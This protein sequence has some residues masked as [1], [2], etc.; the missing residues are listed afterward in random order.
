MA[1]SEG[2]TEFQSFSDRA[3]KYGRN[4]MASSVVV[5]V[6]AWVPAVDLVGSK[7]LNFDIK[8]GNEIWIWGMLLALLLYY[9]I[10]FFGLAAVDFMTW[11]AAH[12][13]SWHSHKSAVANNEKQLVEAQEELQIS[14]GPAA[15]GLA[16]EQRARRKE[17]AEGKVRG[18]MGNLSQSQ[19]KWRDY[20]ARRFYFW[21][22]DL[23]P[24]LVL[25][26]LALV[27]SLMEIVRLYQEQATG[28]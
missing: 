26:L 15:S 17:R 28:T 3:L 27:A 19:E 10:R 4:V 9:G 14:S 18:V 21:A 2:I 25:F 13:G 12:G 8:P 24:P 5:I 20:R 23:A 7:P 1:E 6:L 16:P 11:R 22:T